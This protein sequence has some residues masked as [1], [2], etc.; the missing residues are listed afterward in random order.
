MMDLMYFGYTWEDDSAKFE[1]VFKE[2]ISTIFLDVKLV[3]AYDEI[4]GYRQEVH[5]PED[6][7]DEYLYL[8]L[9]LLYI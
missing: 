2:L 4:K 8:P 7:K 6:K 1:K 5:L 3:N 9:S